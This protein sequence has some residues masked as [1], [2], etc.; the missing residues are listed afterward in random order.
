[1]TGATW[2]GCPSVSAAQW[3]YIRN[4]TGTWSGSN[5]FGGCCFNIRIMTSG[6]MTFRS[7]VWSRAT[8]LITDLIGK[9]THWLPPGRSMRR[10]RVHRRGLVQGRARRRG[11]GLLPQAHGGSRPPP[12]G[13]EAG[14]G[15]GKC[16]SRL[17]FF[18]TYTCDT[19]IIMSK[20]KVFYFY[21]FI[22]LWA[23]EY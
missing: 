14:P 2:I 21:D 15:Q 20:T 11:A 8:I 17:A 7:Q 5:C 1:M 23:R 12:P 22:I 3:V 13:P 16:N 18:P 19:Y 10:L 9:K 4:C 6:N